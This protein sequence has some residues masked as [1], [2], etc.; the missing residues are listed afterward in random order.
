MYNFESLFWLTFFNQLHLD[1]M[2]QKS[3]SQT[4]LFAFGMIWKPNNWFGN[5][6]EDPNNTK[7]SVTKY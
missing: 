2:I 4:V 7:T 5:Q 3:D 6:R 1:M